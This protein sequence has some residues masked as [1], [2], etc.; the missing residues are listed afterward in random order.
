MQAMMRLRLIQ[1]QASCP[2]CGTRDTYSQWIPTEFPLG[3]IWRVRPD[4]VPLCT[5][6]D[7]NQII[8][9][10]ADVFEI[11]SANRPMAHLERCPRLLVG[12]TEVAQMR[13]G[14]ATT[15]SRR[16]GTTHADIIRHDAPAY[17]MKRSGPSTGPS[18]G[19]R[20]RSGPSEPVR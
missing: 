14:K 10:R 2:R 18:Y 17:I 15:T 20:R 19:K 1:L 12:S 6:C 9:P 7:Q 5:D 13:S 4:D 16:S 3:S 11:S 8:A